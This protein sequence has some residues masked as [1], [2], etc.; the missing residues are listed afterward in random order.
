MWAETRD[1]TDAMKAGKRPTKRP[2]NDPVGTFIRNIN[3]ARDLVAMIQA[4]LD[5]HMGVDPDA[6]H[7]GHVGD[8]GRTVVSL[9]EIAVACNLI[10]EE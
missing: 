5:E 3:E 9:K 4:H 8:A 2:D 7:W 1:H 10:P 6:V